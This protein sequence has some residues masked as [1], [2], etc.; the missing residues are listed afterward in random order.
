MAV[1]VVSVLL[2]GCAETGGKQEA[3]MVI[4]A[5]AGGLLGAQ[6][7]SGAGRVAATLVGTAAGT[8]IGGMIGAAM[9]EQDRL[10]LERITMASFESGEAQ[11]YVSPRT[12]ARAE[13]RIVKTTKTAQK[14]CRTASQDV[15][16][17]DGNRSSETVT[18]CKGPDGWVV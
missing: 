4:G 14:I 13:V 16:L 6:F 8:A 9:D 17:S 11:T 10:E 7:G 5:L 12:G 2:Q 3:G 1:A 15:T 18:A